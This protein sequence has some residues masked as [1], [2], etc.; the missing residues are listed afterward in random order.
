MAVSPPRII[1]DT[2]EKSLEADENVICIKFNPW[3]FGTEDE[4][5]TGFFTDIAESL[6]VKLIKTRDNLKK[7]LKKALPSFGEILRAKVAGDAVA[8]FIS[9]PT[10]DE[11][12]KRIE[13]ELESAKK[14]VLILIDDIDRLEKT[15]IHALFR[16][17]KLTADF[18][19]TSYILAFDKDVVAA[20]L[21]DRYSSST[22]DAGEA[23]LEK[24]IQVPLHLPAVEKQV[25]REFCFEGVEEALNI[26]EIELTQQQCQEFYRDFTGAFDDCLTTP[27]K[28]RLY[29]NTLMFSLPILQGEVN[30]VDLMFVEAIRVFCPSLYEVLR[31]NKPLFT[32][33][34]GDSQYTN[35]NENENIKNLI[36]KALKSGR[37]INKEGFIS[38]LK[39]MFPKIQSVYLNTGYGY[40]SDS[41]KKWAK[42]K[43]V[44]SPDYYSRYFAYG[45][46]KGDI[47]DK[48]IQDL[49]D[50]CEKWVDPFDLENNPLN[51]FL[52]A[53]TAETLINKLRNRASEISSD[54]S[55]SL[56]IAVAQKSDVIPNPDVLSRWTL[57]FSQAAM[58]ISDLV[59]NLEKTSRLDFAKK[60]IDSASS[61]E[62]KS[63]IFRYLK[64]E[65]EDKPEK[66]VFSNSDID[67]IGRHLAQVFAQ[68]L[69]KNIDITQLPSESIPTI[70]HTL[71]KFICNN[72]V[73]D[74]VTKLISI[75]PEAIIR[76]LSSY[77][78]TEW[79]IGSSV[80]RKS[81]FDRTAYDRLTSVLDASI[82][83]NVIKHNFSD[84]MN[85]SERFPRV[86]NDDAK[87]DLLFLQQFIWI[88]KRV[89]NEQQSMEELD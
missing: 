47:S 39:S 41:Y 49:S 86:Y 11:L 21:Q 5:L 3:R 71:N 44:C 87:K 73:N 53:A 6:D 40:G 82:I 4:L 68:I 8:S 88:H 36:D 81:D 35:N 30:P 45:I 52:T 12:K 67:E 14:R 26:A 15:E 79:T 13:S 89:L 7:I 75:K 63:Q 70:F 76:I 51:E 57:P 33:L 43:R 56:A 24:I 29:G 84:S 22:E 58:L 34:L 1:R 16:L 64:S 37:N 18:K 38:L 55:I 61:L 25:L 78:P 59:Q 46:P 23:F 60:C 31:I 17:V 20:S 77:V 2:N 72:Y 83:F 65:Q 69:E 32:G 66:D 42:G 9:G 74:Y 85:D 48:A 10:I 62:F 27:R 80:S 50:N 28:A 19:Y 54:A